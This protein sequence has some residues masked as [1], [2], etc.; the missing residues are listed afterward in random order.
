MSG[1]AGLA[2]AKRR[3]AGPSVTTN[4]IP[5]KPQS[6]QSSPPQNFSQ[7]QSGVNSNTHPLVLLLQH[8][9]QL[10]KLQSDINDLRTNNNR[11]T[12]VSTSQVDEQSIQYFKAKYESLTQEMEEMKKLLI[13]IQTFSMESNLEL[14]KMKRALKNDP[15]LKESDV[16]EAS[17]ENLSL[18]N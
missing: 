8:E 4:E 7:I 10:N 17:L 9:Q 11:Q 3:R 5:K 14:I 12:V 18:N 16:D 6:L 15:R 13:K 1:A 2:A